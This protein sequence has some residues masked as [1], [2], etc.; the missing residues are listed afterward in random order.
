[1][2][3]KRGTVY[4]TS[5][6]LPIKYAFT[7][8]LRRQAKL[9]PNSSG[10]TLVTIK[11]LIAFVAIAILS[12]CS[13]L[14]PSGDPV[15]AAPADGPPNIIVVLADDM[16]IGD[17]GFEGHPL[18]NTPHIDALAEKSVFFRNAFATSPI[19][20]PSRTSILTGLYERS[21]GINFNSDTVMT[22]EAFLQTYP[23]RLREAGYFVGYV[24]KNH[25]PV[26][27]NEDGQTGYESSI[28]ERHFD[29]WYGS[30]RHLGFYPKQ[31]PRHAIFRNA[32]SHTQIEILS[33]GIANFF[34][35][36]E[37][38]EA[39]ADFLGRRPS[40]QPYALLLNFN[41]PHRAGTGSMKMLPEDDD[42]YRNAYRD[43]KDHIVLPNTYVEQ[44]N[45]VDPKIP[46]H[47]YN[48]EQIASYHYVHTPD[49]LREHETRVMQTITGMDR[50]LGMIVAQLERD[51]L[52][53][54][55]V[56]V[57]T[58]DHGIMAGEHGLGGKSLLYE[59]SIRVPL[60]IYDPKRREGRVREE[61]VGLIDIAPTLL[62][63]AGVPGG[64]EMQGE[65]LVPLMRSEPTDWRDSLFLENLMTIQNYP[66]IEGVRTQ[67]L[68]YMRYFDRDNDG[69]YGDML[70]G[71]LSGEHP[72]YEELYDLRSDN[73]E[74][75]NLVEDPDYADTLV[76]MRAET[77]RLLEQWLND[78]P[79]R[80][81]PK[82]T[83]E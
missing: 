11:R 70:L 38:F 69:S 59:P 3:A 15:R 25:T 64:E 43:L 2:T 66:R 40:G 53:E 50:V 68:K 7:I 44:S 45:V 33:E 17:T 6:D 18:I 52:L 80:T 4:E 79:A 82:A 81:L 76:D 36:N 62:E 74:T 22:E 83:Q 67:E 56:I 27:R 51:H 73:D 71:S 24:G 60:I 28:M 77:T 32:V 5:G 31:N 78:Q 41:V 39:G 16:R 58:S 57:F 37:V 35:P 46:E 10:N 75:T 19:C 34:E 14:Q 12:N 23:M 8:I 55:T 63:L 49:E 1:L 54:N 26:G 20:T 72:I 47:V 42:L 61:L 29:Y 65:S 48:G 30:H 13:D 9:G 21:H